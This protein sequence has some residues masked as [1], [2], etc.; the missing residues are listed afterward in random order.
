MNFTK[1]AFVILLAIVVAIAPIAISVK[2]SDSNTEENPSKTVATIISAP[3]FKS[4]KVVSVGYIKKDVT[5]HI[6]GNCKYKVNGKKYSTKEKIV[7][8]YRGKKLMG[9]KTTKGKSVKFTKVKVRYGKKEKFS[10]VL[11]VKIS[12][13]RAKVADCSFKSK[14]KRISKVKAFATKISK[15]K[16]YLRWT[17]D[18]D[19]SGFYIYKG[20]KK[21]KITKAQKNMCMIKEKGIGSSKIRVAAF[22]KDEEKIHE[23]KSKKVKPKK[24]QV[25][26]KVNKIVKAQA[27]STCKFAISKITLSGNVYT[28]TGYA[29]NN[30]VY[31]MKK[32]KKL[33]IALMVDN[34]KA[35][36]K[37]FKNKRVNAKENS[38]KMI[39]LKIK[40]KAGKDL[41]NGAVSLS[42]KEQPDWGKSD[43]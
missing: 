13:K 17:K 6:N 7:E 33:T 9:T 28:V 14:T 19:V 12:N 11:Y 34:K 37:T 21:V 35:F 10:A 36:K 1:K 39:V 27:Y 16:A 22:V 2:A 41:A 5:L 24:N 26:W 4:Y 42:T 38:A 3:T 8:L 25:E 29:L 23:I 18:P 31:E 43:D 32:Y 15:N 20:N 30:R 40:G